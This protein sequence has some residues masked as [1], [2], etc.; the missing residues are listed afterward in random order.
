MKV[1]PTNADVFCDAS[2]VGKSLS[3]DQ[4]LPTRQFSA[5]SELGTL[6]RQVEG[7]KTKE[8]ARTTKLNSGKHLIVYTSGADKPIAA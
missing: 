5:Q 6:E 7:T 1:L 2:L 3:D 8:A 4:T